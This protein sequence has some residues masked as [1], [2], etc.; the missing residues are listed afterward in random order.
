[1]VEGRWHLELDRT[2]FTMVDFH[3]GKCNTA[4]QLPRSTPQ[5]EKTCS[6][7]CFLS[8]MFLSS[9]LICLRQACR[10]LST[11]HT[12]FLNDYRTTLFVSTAGM[13][14]FSRQVA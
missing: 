1:M 10:K 2:A 12:L 3:I 6:S 4:A 7:D 9:S 5:D 8:H 14:T 11:R 13:P